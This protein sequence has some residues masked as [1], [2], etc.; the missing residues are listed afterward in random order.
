MKQG[1]E[2]VH[3]E[4]ID[5]AEDRAITRPLASLTAYRDDRRKS[6]GVLTIIIYLRHHVDDV[7]AEAFLGCYLDRVVVS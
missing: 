3:N 7:A 4:T 2:I 5:G 6:D 1:A